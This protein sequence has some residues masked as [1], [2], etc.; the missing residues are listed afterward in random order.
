MVDSHIRRRT[1][2]SKLI[3]DKSSLLGITI[4]AIIVVAGV[5]APVI[6]PMSPYTQVL[7]FRNQKPGFTGEIILFRLT[8]EL[9]VQTVAVTSISKKGETIQYQDQL[10]RVFKIEKNKC[11]KKNCTLNYREIP[12]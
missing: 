9:P 10:N 8:P 1:V 6:A 2:F 11:H 12:F 3:R 4:I 5:F 7:E